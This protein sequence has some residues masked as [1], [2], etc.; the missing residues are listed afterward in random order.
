VPWT[1][2][3]EVLSDPGYLITGTGAGSTSHMEGSPWPILKIS[4]EYG[5]VAMISFVV[6]VASAFVGK[7]NIPLRFAAWVVFNFTGGYLFDSVLITT[8]SLLF[9]IIEPV[10]SEAGEAD[11][12]FFRR[13]GPAG[14]LNRRGRLGA[15]R[16]GNRL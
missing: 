5:V 4:L 7:R 10:Q 12:E 11:L 15:E 16:Q 3:I 14:T 1:R 9:C 13:E 2:L 6:F 8:F